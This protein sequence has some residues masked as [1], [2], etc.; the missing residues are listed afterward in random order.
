MAI[1]GS[2]VESAPI[3][4]TEKQA[5]AVLGEMVFLAVPMPLFNQLSDEAAKRNQTLAQLL[6]AALS[7]YLK[8]SIGPQLLTETKESR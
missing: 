6:S 3:P 4:A 7:E 1:K 2:A 5:L 8:K